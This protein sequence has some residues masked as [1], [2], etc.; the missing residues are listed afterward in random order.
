MDAYLCV[1]KR[2]QISKVKRLEMK[3]ITFCKV[4]HKENIRQGLEDGVRRKGVLG[5]KHGLR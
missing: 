5:A 2:T 4:E 3:K 1:H